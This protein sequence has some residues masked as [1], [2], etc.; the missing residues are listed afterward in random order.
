MLIS[1]WILFFIFRAVLPECMGLAPTGLLI[2]ILTTTA[3]SKPHAASTPVVALAHTFR[4]RTAVFAKVQFSGRCQGG[5]G[6]EI[7]RLFRGGGVRPTLRQRGRSKFLPRQK[8]KEQKT[9]QWTPG[10]SVKPTRQG[11]E[12]PWKSSSTEIEGTSGMG[13]GGGAY[14]KCKRH[15]SLASLIK[16]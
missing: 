9:G 7:P 6:G 10:F 4:A 11:Q 3:P 13:E 2:L 14:C 5:G 1:Y 16:V 15:E 8:F 12:T